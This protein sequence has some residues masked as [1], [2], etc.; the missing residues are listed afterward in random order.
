MEIYTISVFV[1]T[2][3]AAHFLK[4]LIIHRQIMTMMMFVS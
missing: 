3:D 1:Y 4:A 2:R